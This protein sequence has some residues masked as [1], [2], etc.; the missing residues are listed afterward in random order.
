MFRK[1]SVITICF[2]DCQALKQ[3]IDSVFEQ[4]YSDVEFI[5]VDGGSTD[6]TVDLLKLHSHGISKY[7][8]EKDDGIYDAMNKGIQ[9]SSGDW[10]IFM[11]AGDTFYSEKTIS[12]L[13]LIPECDEADVIYG[14]HIVVD[15]RRRNGHRIALE[16][17]YY[18]Q[19]MICCHQSMLFKRSCF[20]ERMFS[21]DFGESGDYEFF[22]YLVRLRK[23]LCK[24]DVIVSIFSGGG[25]SDTN[26][27]ST[28]MNGFKA[29]KANHLLNVKSFLGFSMLYF[30]AILFQLYSKFESSF[31]KGGS[32]N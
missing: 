14:D 22:L 31:L 1:V 29:L 27:M 30:R 26:R 11:N 24:V 32:I 10:L 2:N 21:C 20:E 25:V 3:T 7:V 28:V 12:R 18:Y 5:V 19:G 23:R 9:M 4:D 8:S 17:E 13:A 15:A 6:K 16:P